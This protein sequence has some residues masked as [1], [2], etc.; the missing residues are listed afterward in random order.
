MKSALL[1]IPALAALF[2]VSAAA[3]DMASISSGTGTE[4]TVY[5]GDWIAIGG[6]VLYSPSYDGSNDYTVSP[7]PLVEGQVKG[8]GI[9]PRPAGLALNFIPPSKDGINFS[10]GPSVRLRSDRAVQ[11]VDPVVEKAG[12]LK[13]SLEVGPSVGISIPKLL[14]PYDSLSFGIE[15]RWDVLGASKGMVFAPSITYFTPVSR[16]I[17]VGLS[18]DAERGDDNF[19]NYYYSV[20]P[21]Q[22][23]ASGLPQYHASAGFTEAGAT[24]I[25]GIDLDGNLANG[26]FALLLVGG[27]SRMLG[28]AAASPYTSIR[29][30]RDQWLGAV[31]LGYVF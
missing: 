16:G 5:D 8:I 17:A 7:V 3:Q 13:R 2:S 6:G 21:A 18:L 9:K 26:G 14:N 15:A 27:Y 24:L 11:I 20:S 4:K 19:M 1:L 28:D 12:K 29:G 10:L 31:G 30:S 23:A 22:A 25:T